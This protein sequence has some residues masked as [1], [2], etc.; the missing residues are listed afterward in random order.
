MIDLVPDP[1]EVSHRDLCRV[2]AAW[3]LTLP[4]CDVACWELNGIEPAAKRKKSAARRREFYASVEHMPVGGERYRL[5]AEHWK[6]E[7]K[8]SV[9]DAVA[10]SDQARHE[11][12]IAWANG[13]KRKAPPKPRLHIVEVKRTRADL[14]SDLRAGKLLKYERLGTHCSLAATPEALAVDEGS[15]WDVDRQA[16]CGELEHLGLPRHWG[17]VLLRGEHF[18]PF[19][20]RPARRLQ[21]VIIPD[22]RARLISSIA[23]SM[24]HRVLGTSPMEERWA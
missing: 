21:T 20:L 7:P 17:V 14:L 13:A 18:E 24:V 2:V 23:R 16:V 5:C 3:L 10:V 19:T 6:T 22:D 15:A 1:I 4:W 9:F 11:Q 12:R 8:A